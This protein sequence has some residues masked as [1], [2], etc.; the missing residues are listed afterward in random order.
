MTFFQNFQGLDIPPYFFKDV[1]KKLIGTLLWMN[2][3]KKNLLKAN[4]SHVWAYN[5]PADPPWGRMYGDAVPAG[6][7]NEQNDR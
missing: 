5:R 4:Q 6:G 7:G 2:E 1:K 3:L